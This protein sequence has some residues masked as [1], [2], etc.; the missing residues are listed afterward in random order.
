M[1]ALSKILILNNDTDDEEL[2]SIK[3]CLYALLYMDNGAYTGNSNE[4]KKAYGLLPKI[5]NPYGFH[6]QQLVTNDS[7][8]Q[9]QIDR[10]NN[11]TTDN[12]VKLLGLDW[13]RISDF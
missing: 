13:N 7:N 8:L 5:F 12:S 11:V 10:E 3:R 1:L 9:N 4:L 2:K 6:I